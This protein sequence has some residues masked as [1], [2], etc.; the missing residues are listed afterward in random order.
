MGT[1]PADMRDGSSDGERRAWAERRREKLGTSRHG[2]QCV[3][4]CHLHH[5]HVRHLKMRI[6]LPLV[7][8]EHIVQQLLA[9][10]RPHSTA[11]ASNSGTR[12]GAR[13]R[14]APAAAKPHTVHT[15]VP[16]KVRVNVISDRPQKWL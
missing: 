9:S 6:R 16:D 14:R 5:E 4:F 15:R 13:A 11:I 1:H 7:G 3:L 10:S 12:A 2:V 8:L